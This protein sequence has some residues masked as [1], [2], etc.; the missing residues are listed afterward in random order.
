MFSGHQ[1][2]I[3]GNKGKQRK[4]KQNTAKHNKDSNMFWIVFAHL[5]VKD[6]IWSL[7]RSG[8]RFVSGSPIQ[9]SV[10]SE[11]ARQRRVDQYCADGC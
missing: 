8:V 2:K 5:R 11:V 7:Y 4:T 1:R 9:T 10:Y 6:D 3:V